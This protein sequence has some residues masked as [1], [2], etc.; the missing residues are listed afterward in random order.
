MPQLPP[1]PPVPVLLR[2]PSSSCLPF[3]LWLFFLVL[4]VVLA[5]L[6]AALLE[7]LHLGDAHVRTKLASQNGPSLA[8]TF[9]NSNKNFSSL[10][11]STCVKAMNL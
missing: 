3:V 10:S 2:L 6:A 9:I 8:Q 7:N 4:P 1:L 5:T 11:A